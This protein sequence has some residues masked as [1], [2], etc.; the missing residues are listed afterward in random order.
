M[1]ANLVFD[2]PD[3]ERAF[4]RAA[5]ADELYEA[6]MDIRAM[7]TVGGSIQSQILA[8]WDDSD[9]V[10]NVRLRLKRLKNDIGDLG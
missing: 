2:I 5:R 1:M 10:S 8:P 4:M 3:E 9:I 7:V 6:L